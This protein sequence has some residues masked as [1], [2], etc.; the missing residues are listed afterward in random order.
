MNLLSQRGAGVKIG[1]EK[2]YECGRLM[3][4]DGIPRSTRY[5]GGLCGPPPY[6]LSNDTLGTVFEK[7]ISRTLKLSENKEQK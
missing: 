3:V 1:H 4:M 5:G 6:L 7:V 2:A